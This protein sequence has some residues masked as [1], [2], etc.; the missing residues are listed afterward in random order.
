MTEKMISDFYRHNFEAEW[1]HSTQL[2]TSAYL[3]VS[4]MPQSASTS[5]TQDVLFVE[6]SN[7]LHDRYF[8]TCVL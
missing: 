5:T 3:F 8:Q 1:Q 6:V 2:P 7:S 4:R